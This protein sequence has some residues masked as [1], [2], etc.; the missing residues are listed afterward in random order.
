MDPGIKTTEFKI[1]IAVIVICAAA[2]G[3]ALY[4]GEG[5]SAAIALALA[6]AKALGYDAA[7]FGVKA[8][9]LDHSRAVVMERTADKM[10]EHV[11]NIAKVGA[12]VAAGVI[13]GRAL[14]STMEV[15]DRVAGRTPD[16]NGGVTLKIDG[17]D[18]M[19]PLDMHPPGR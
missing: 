12:P 13:A 18:V 8:R 16:G 19:N 11:A 9:D 6:V 1:T 5:V 2:A 3:I 17:N 10:I 15:S 14:D 7:R 4:Q